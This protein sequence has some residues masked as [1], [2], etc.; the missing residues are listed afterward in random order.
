MLHDATIAVAW[1]DGLD[2]SHE[3]ILDAVDQPYAFA[4]KVIAVGF[5]PAAAARVDVD[6]DKNIRFP[7]I[8]R[9]HDTGIPWAF[10]GQIMALQETY[11]TACRLQIFTAKAAVG[12]GQVTLAQTASRID[13]ARV[14]ITAQR[15]TWVQKDKYHFDGL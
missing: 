11:L 7:R 5:R 9:L 15:M 6:A 4:A 1:V 12:Y 10:T 8:G 3:L 13:A 2:G 14:G